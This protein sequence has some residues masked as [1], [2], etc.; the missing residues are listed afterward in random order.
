MFVCV[1]KI[2]NY[3]FYLDVNTQKTMD[4]NYSYGRLVTLKVGSRCF[5]SY[6]LMYIT[7]TTRK[8][9]PNSNYQRLKNIS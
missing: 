9:K 8:R 6:V 7:R 3:V 4:F 5:V 2:V 1:I